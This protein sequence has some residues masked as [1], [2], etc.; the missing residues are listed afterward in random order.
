MTQQPVDPAK[1]ATFAARVLQDW[2]GAHIVALAY[3]GDRLGIFRALADGGPMTSQQLAH[4]TGLNERYLRE[5]AAAMAAAE[6][7]G[8]LGL[9]P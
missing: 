4:R 8:D 5:W 6:P 9:E 7:I 2:G 3:I 1:I